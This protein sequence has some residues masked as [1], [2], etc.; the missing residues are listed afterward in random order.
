MYPLSI[1]GHLKKIN[2]LNALKL[3][4]MKK[5]S[6]LNESYIKKQQTSLKELFRT[7]I[8]KFLYND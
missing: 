4:K 2:M 8:H 7:K 1:W 3:K 6:F 5:F